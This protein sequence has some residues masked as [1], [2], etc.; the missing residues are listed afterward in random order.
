LN[1]DKNI[2]DNP[3]K[4]ILIENMRI[5]NLMIFLNINFENSVKFILK[6]KKN[7]ID[8]G[9][10]RRANIKD[11]IATIGMAFKRGFSITQYINRRKN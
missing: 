4:T 11:I 1:A 3:V 9:I 6:S 10:S 2:L 5:T 8:T 7:K